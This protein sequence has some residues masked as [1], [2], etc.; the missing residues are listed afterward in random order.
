MTD[1][2]R[3]TGKEKPRCSKDITSSVFISSSEIR[4]CLYL[5]AVSAA[6]KLRAVLKGMV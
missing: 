4:S 5:P 1:S 6:N 2:G 3:E